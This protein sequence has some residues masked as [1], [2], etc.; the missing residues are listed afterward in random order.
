[1]SDATAAVVTGIVRA[2]VEAVFEHVDG[3]RLAVET[4]FARPGTVRLADFT[5]LY[6]ALTA[7]VREPDGLVR[8]AGFVAAPG[9][10]VDAPWW[11]EWFTRESLGEPNRLVLDVDPTSD[12]FHDYTTLPW[13]REPARTG[14]RHITGP[15]VDYLCTDEYTLT[16]TAPVYA[17]RSGNDPFEDIAAFSGVV[18]TDVD[19]SR[20]EAIV[21]PAL[22]AVD[23]PAALVNDHNRVIAANSARHP[24]GTLLRGPELA[25]ARRVRCGDS[26]VS[27]ILGALH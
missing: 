24:A 19:V 3:V 16:F 7:P 15:Y 10:L 17:A 18:G 11:L 14:R 26:P 23:G 12:R 9:V 20:F 6:P 27:L 5:A 1:V 8:G 4:V 13:Y 21:L 22:Q 25:G 2:T